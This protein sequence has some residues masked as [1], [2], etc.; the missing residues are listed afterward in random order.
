MY[1]TVL[2]YA[3]IYEST[4]INNI[5]DGSLQN[6]SFLQVFHFQ[7]IR[8]ENWLGHILTRV[9]GRLLQLLHNIPE[10][11]LTDSKFFGHLLIISY[12]K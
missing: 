5:T 1:Q 2:M 6:H 3:D 9:T 7:H 8:A 4:E 10:G 11:D 12:Q